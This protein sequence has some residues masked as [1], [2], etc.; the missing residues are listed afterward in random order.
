MTS[1][2]HASRLCRLSHT[3]FPLPFAFPFSIAVSNPQRGPEQRVTLCGS[4][5]WCLFATSARCLRRA[6]VDG[7]RARV[8][9]VKVRKRD[10]TLSYLAGPIDRCHLEWFTVNWGCCLQW[11][12]FLLSSL[13]DLCL[14]LFTVRFTGVLVLHSSTCIC[15]YLHLYLSQH[16]HPYLSITLRQA[17]SECRCDAIKQASQKINQY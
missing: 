11:V 13:S 8:D 12:F 7:R 3:R 4:G 6:T 17:S 1:S 15:K 16:L 5:S 2:W 10:E 9:C 14:Y